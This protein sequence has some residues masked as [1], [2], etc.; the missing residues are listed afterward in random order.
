MQRLILRTAIVIVASTLTFLPC[1]HAADKTSSAVDEANIRQA[2]VSQN[3][4]IAAQDPDLVASF[5]TEDVTIRRG[6][7]QPVSGQAAYRSSSSQGEV[8]LLA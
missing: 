8:R 7:G 2:R 3:Q 6:L 1:L 5:W 4:A